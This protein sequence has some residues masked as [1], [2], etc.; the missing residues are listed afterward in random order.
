M[1]NIKP[2]LKR[3]EHEEVSADQAVQSILA[4]LK[5]DPMMYGVFDIWDKE[6]SGLVRN[7]EAVG[8][9]GTRLCVRVPSTV[10]RQELLYVKDRI[11]SKVN[12]AMGRR[13]ITDV[14]FELNS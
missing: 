14:Y 7:C 8:I 9:Q 12:Q 6:T 10:H 3:G 11:I 1:F 4:L 5:F 2:F 13:V